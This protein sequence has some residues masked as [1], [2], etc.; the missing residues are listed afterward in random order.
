[1]RTEI[2]FGPKMPW[3]EKAYF[4]TVDYSIEVAGH[5]WD[6]GK[7]AEIYSLEMFETDPEKP[8]LLYNQDTIPDHFLDQI[9][10]E[11]CRVS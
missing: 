3:G 8:E 2:Y 11:L 10:E 6:L 4:V 1:M 5:E 7:V 9:K